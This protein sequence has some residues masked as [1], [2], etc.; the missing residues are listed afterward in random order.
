MQIN[1]CFY[2]CT[3]ALN[4]YLMCGYVFKYAYEHICVLCVF[5]FSCYV[6]VCVF[7]HLSIYE[8]ICICICVNVC[9]CCVN[10]CVYVHN[11]Y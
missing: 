9:V 10:I 7:D 4:G 8:C 6:D 11:A 5:V 2:V 1:V 3:F